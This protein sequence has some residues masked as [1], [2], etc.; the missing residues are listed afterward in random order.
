M[1]KK[2]L[3]VNAYDASDIH[4][5]DS[6][7]QCA[8]YLDYSKHSRKKIGKTCDQGGNVMDLLAGEFYV[9]FFDSSFILKHVNRD[10]DNPH[11]SLKQPTV[12]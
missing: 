9:E 5:Y 7:S 8:E 12:H 4:V 2:V 10:L 6:L 1:S 3:A 11:V